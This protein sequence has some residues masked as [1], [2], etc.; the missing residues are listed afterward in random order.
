M[1]MPMWMTKCN[2]LFLFMEST[3]LHN[4]YHWGTGFL[5]GNYS[6]RYTCQCVSLSQDGAANSW[7]SQYK[8]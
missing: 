6:D 4:M 1:K 3:W 7:V 8:H 5:Y 2:L